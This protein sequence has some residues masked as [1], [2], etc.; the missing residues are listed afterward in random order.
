MLA[1]PAMAR[2]AGD[3]HD[4]FY[5]YVETR[6]KTFDPH[7]PGEVVDHFS[8][9]LRILQEDLLLPGKA[10]HDLRIVRAYSS[11][12]WGRTDLLD[13][14]P[15]LAEKDPS[16]LGYGWSLHMGRL[17]RPNATGQPLACGGGDYPV[18]EAPDGTARTFYPV[19]GSNREFLSRDKWKLDR[20]CMTGRGPGACITTTAGEK[21]EFAAS[22]A[23]FVGVLPVWPLAARA[24]VFGNAIVVT[25]HQGTGRIN[26]ITDTWNRTVEFGYAACGPRQ[27]LQSIR[28]AGP[29]GSRTVTYTYT[30]FSVPEAGGSRAFL[31]GVQPAAG[32]GYA[33]SYG[34]SLPV[35]ENRYALT[36]ISYPFGGNTAYTYA[37]RP[38]F[39]GRQDVPMAV[40]RTR[41]TSGRALPAGATWTYEYDA[42]SNKDVQTT[43]V[44]RP[45]GRA[46]VYE[47]VGFGFPLRMNA[48]GS[49]WKVGL[50]T[51]VSRGSGAEI[52]ES[53][54]EKGARVTTANFAAPF[55]AAGAC[56]AWL[57][58]TDVQTP[59]LTKRVV[60]RD[61]SRY[62]TEMAGYDMFGQPGTVT[63]IGEAQRTTAKPRRVTTYTYA[64]DMATNQVV[65]RVT[66]EQACQGTGTSDCMVTERTFAGPHGAKDSETARGVKTG[67]DYW[68]DGNLWHVTNAMGQALALEGYGTGYGI[69]TRLDFNGAFTIDR[70]AFWDGRLESE[71]NGRGD[72]TEYDY[73]AAGR[74]ETITPPGS[75]DATT[76]TYAPNGASYSTRRGSGTSAYV[77]T[78][79]LDGLG[80][81]IETSTS[82]GEKRTREYDGLGR[83]IFT[84]YAFAPGTPEVGDRIVYDDLGRPRV[85]ERRFVATGHRPLMGHCATPG[86][87]EITVEHLIDHCR[88]TTVD[89]APGDSTA[90]RACF[91]SFGDP[92]EE[93][94]RSTADAL[95]KAWGYSYDVAGNLKTF[96]APKAAGNRS[97]TY[98]PGTFFTA[99][100]TSGP[101]G[102]TTVTLH[103]DLGHPLQQE[104]ATGATTT[105]EYADPLSR[106]TFTKYDG[107]TT[108][109]DVERTYDKDV[110][111]TISSIQGGTYTYGYDELGRLTSQTWDFRGQTYTTTYDYDASGCLRGLTYPTGT[112][113]RMTCDAKGRPLTVN[114]DRMGTVEAIARDVTYHPMGRVETMTFGNGLMVRAVVANGRL[115]S[116]RTAGVL[117]LAFGYD[118]ADNVTSVTDALVPANTLSQVTYDA[119]DRIYDV[120]TPAG[121][122][123]YRYDELG[124]RTEKTVP[125]EGV[126]KYTYNAATNRLDS[127]LG[128][129][130][131]S[132]MTLKWSPAERVAAVSGGY[133]FRYDGLG[134]RVSKLVSNGPEVV[135]HHDQQ[136][137]LLAE[138]VVGG[139]VIREYF[140]VADQLVAVHG[141][142]AGNGTG[143]SALEWVHTDQLGSVRARTDRGGMVAARME[144]RPWGESSASGP[145][146]F[147]GRVAD[148]G[149]GLYDFGAR[150]YAPAIGR[151]ISPDTVW[152]RS[153]PQGANA[154][155]FVLDNPLKHTDPDGHLPLL[156][157]TGIAGG[158]IGGAWAAY[159]ARHLSGAAFVEEVAWGVVSG[160]LTGVGM[161]GNAPM[162]TV[163]SRG[164]WYLVAERSIKLGIRNLLYPTGI[165]MKAYQT[166]EVAADSE[167]AARGP[168][169]EIPSYIRSGELAD[170]LQALT[171]PTASGRPGGGGGK[172]QDA[173]AT[174][175]DPPALP[176]TGAQ[177]PGAQTN[178]TDAGNK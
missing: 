101:R 129:S 140:Y 122:A 177:A 77:E 79:S 1:W 94:L 9:T 27:C 72:V 20:Q 64:R 29:G 62:E 24:D 164:G 51:K 105:F 56:S 157:I 5:R 84:S 49:V 170:D 96:T 16:P 11:R 118:G 55:Y 151:F 174:A 92:S 26:V 119:L 38:F 106:P 168:M 95:A 88:R 166:A 48:T 76:Y 87:C 42:P 12:I 31:T 14:E 19:V 137:R 171:H 136:G 4:Q 46:D 103:D 109:N 15:F 39:A 131:L 35:T 58:D 53:T 135:Y 63:E 178:S 139:G 45:D 116:I 113:A 59:I 41:T 125:G 100:E 60:T 83:L 155:A 149:T 91:E 158:V 112:V 80:R 93:R 28:A 71:S 138:T 99:T 69:A 148:A 70:T 98:T 160:A 65:G 18:Y 133:V 17:L 134:R 142:P 23:Y 89:R 172:A 154:Y 86:A 97:L 102:T 67:F 123:S 132:P 110:L 163:V 34:T 165:G 36:S 61:G 78:T 117:D 128:P 169:P 173:K 74:L 43:T 68:P 145:L 30:S 111:K 25:Y 90:T 57:W 44:T 3:V 141:C 66:R 115:Q 176:A 130:A 144:Y 143:C 108:N 153:N 159:D 82:T 54:W 40:V 156:A 81:V 120:T 107:P 33:Y 124:N 13:M 146:L 167:E 114:R 50:Q 22:D 73:D 21:L 2:A 7:L 126:T 147:N 127:S 6:N 162:T 10:G 121:I 37:T 175:V 8:G 75:N 104:D 150:A 47:F 32:P 85:T 152:S 161:V 52:E